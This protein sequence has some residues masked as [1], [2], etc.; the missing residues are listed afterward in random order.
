MLI[1]TKLFLTKGVGR[2]KDKLQSFELALRSAGIQHCN[3]V[4]VSSI[5]PPNCEIIPAKEG[6]KLLQRAREE[7]QKAGYDKNWLEVWEHINK[8]LAELQ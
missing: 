2:H 4:S 1:P 3:L 8:R 6:I 7:Y 5:I